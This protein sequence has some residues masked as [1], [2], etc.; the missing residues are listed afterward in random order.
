M[1]KDELFE[2]VSKIVNGIAQK[3]TT[4]ECRGFSLDDVIQSCILGLLRNWDN[5]DPA[6][7]LK[8]SSWVY[9]GC[10]MTIKAMW[11]KEKRTAEYWNKFLEV[12]G[13]SNKMR[14]LTFDIRE[15]L[16]LRMSV[17]DVVTTYSLDLTEK[18]MAILMNIMNQ[19][20][21][22]EV[23]TEHKMDKSTFYATR[24]RM[25]RHLRKRMKLQEVVPE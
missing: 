10:L 22:D 21:R 2:N 6:F 7:N 13:R 14:T 5:Y 20:T 19:K 9:N 15:D 24:K 11:A 4:K 1:T 23:L 8:R 12:T 16:A 17:E 18:E 25:R 3:W